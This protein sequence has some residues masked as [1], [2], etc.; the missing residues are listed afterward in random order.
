MFTVF[1]IDGGKKQIFN[2]EASRIE[3]SDVIF[4][5]DDV[6]V[7]GDIRLTIFRKK[8][9][10]DSLKPFC[11]LALH[12]SLLDSRGQIHFQKSDL[13]LLSNDLSHKLSCAAFAIRLEYVVGIPDQLT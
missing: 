2:L 4:E 1:P 7:A 12:T 5:P 10:D 6:E 11:S 9:P 3:D 13:D 8:A